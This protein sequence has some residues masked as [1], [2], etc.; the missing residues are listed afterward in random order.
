M[1]Q[2]NRVDLKLNQLVNDLNRINRQLLLDFPVAEYC[3]S[4]KAIPLTRSYSSIPRSLKHKIETIKS[5]YG[6]AAVATYHKLVL[7]YFIK[8]S[9][10]I[11]QDEIFPP[12]ITSFYGKHFEWVFE[13]FEKKPSDGDHYTYNDDF[14]LKDLS[15]CSL[16]MFPAG[17]L[18][19]E[20]SLVNWRFILRSI[21]YGGLSQGKLSQFIEA[22]RFYLTKVKGNMP[23]YETHTDG[24]WLRE[25]NQAGW[26][27]FYLRIAEMLK[28]NPHI[29]GVLGVSWFFDPHLEQISP[30]LLYLRQIPEQGGA[31]IFR[32]GTNPSDIKN[33]TAVSP[34]RRKLYEEGKYM[35]TSYAVIWLRDELIEWANRSDCNTNRFENI[36]S[37][38]KK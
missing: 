25:F 10:A 18:T 22:N 20:L 2:E 9:L 5:K 33:A 1:M 21:K 19:V 27:K 6:P 14:F 36:E 31:K 3:R 13:D 38:Q 35:P 4:I 12:D 34:K 29:Q 17:A 8:E 7:C 23:F 28:N 32:F 11:L 37:D 16:K 26:H 30:N 24:R 15:I